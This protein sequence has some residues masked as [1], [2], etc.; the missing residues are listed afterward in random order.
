MRKEW[1]RILQIGNVILSLSPSPPLPP[2][3]S[4]QKI[5]VADFFSNE[6]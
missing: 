1:R 2:K 6:F 5:F 4:N 3:L